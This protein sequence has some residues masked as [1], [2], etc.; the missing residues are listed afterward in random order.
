MDCRRQW[1]CAPL[2]QLLI[3]SASALPSPFM[4]P[5]IFKVLVRLPQGR[6]SRISVNLAPKG[7]SG[8]IQNASERFLGKLAWETRPRTS[9]E[10]G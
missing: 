9:T 5:V 1:S 8:A 2:L 6:A 10:V 7:P 3:L 4:K